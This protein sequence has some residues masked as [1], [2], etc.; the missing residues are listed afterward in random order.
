LK[1]RLFSVILFVGVV[2]Q[3]RSQVVQTQTDPNRL[4]LKDYSPHSIYKIPVSKISRA[5]YPV[6]D[7]H[8]HPYAKTPAEVRRWVANMDASGIEKTTILT[9]LT[10]TEF[11]K[12]Q[13]LYNAY[14]G[15]F[16]LW[17]GLDFSQ[18]QSPHFTAAAL[19]QLEY[20]YRHGAKGIG[21]LSDKGEGFAFGKQFARGLHAD[22]KRMDPIF[23]K[24]AD[25]KIPV[26]MHIAEP[27]WMYEPM[28]A[29]NDG[30]MNAAEW[31]RDVKGALAQHAALIRSLQAAVGKHPRTLFIAC[32]FANL[33]TDLDQLGKMLDQYPN[34]Y[35][36]I[37]ARYGE[38]A[39]IPRYMLA[40][41]KRHANKLLYGTDM[42][43]E[44]KMYQG[45][46]RI[47]E[48]LDEHFYDAEYGYHWPLSGFGLP[49]DVLK[50]IYRE[51][52]LEILAKHSN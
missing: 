44:L 40:F 5:K 11:E 36:D 49:D 14:P 13:Q 6:I 23:E 32:H 35:A 47:L 42:G 27:Q 1:H 21:E 33:E 48:T 45:T 10:G 39:P 25:L 30:L 20:C 37:S 34:L 12:V 7:M 41:Y 38:T 2:A 19:Q 16:E 24:L 26:N 29:Q 46:F 43:Y 31:R 17:A 8:S 22:D 50:R 52:A 3:A 18:Y 28:D 9:K 51:N 15:R 4:L